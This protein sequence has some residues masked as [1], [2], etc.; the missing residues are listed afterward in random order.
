MTIELGKKTDTLTV[1]V[2]ELPLTSMN[3]RLMIQVVRPL[4]VVAEEYVL[5]FAEH[6]EEIS[7]GQTNLEKIIGDK[8]L[9]RWKKLFEPASANPKT[10]WLCEINKVKVIWCDLM[11]PKEELV[12]DE[13][14]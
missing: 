14:S 8:V 1:W 7:K 6:A 3:I 10:A 9:E 5:P 4:A 11:V 2:A 13:K 12:T